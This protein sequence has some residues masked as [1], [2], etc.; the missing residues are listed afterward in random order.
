MPKIEPVTVYNFNTPKFEY[1]LGILLDK[2]QGVIGDMTEESGIWSIERLIDLQD[3]LGMLKRLKDGTFKIKR[4]FSDVK[5]LAP[6]GLSMPIWAAGVTF[7]SSTLARESESGQSGLYAKVYSD[8]RP[9]LFPK[10]FP[11]TA[12]HPGDNIGIRPD[13]EWNVPEPELVLIFN[14]KGELVAMTAGNDVSSRAIEG[15]NPLYLPQAKIYNQSCAI[16]SGLVFGLRE[17]DARQCQTRLEI[18]RNGEVEFDKTST[19]GNMKRTFTELRDHLFQPLN[20]PNGVALFTGTDLVPPDRWTLQEGDLV[21]ISI[22]GITALKN[23]VKV[24][25]HRELSPIEPPQN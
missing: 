16:G 21:R 10:A 1:G 6:V 13:S 25:P 5:V 18:I 23:T 19:I 14:S 8:P 7:A 20:H 17:E 4:K 11:G 9:E 3:L 24:I 15:C 2:D 22:S 12:V